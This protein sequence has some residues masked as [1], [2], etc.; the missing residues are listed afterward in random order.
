MARVAGS[1]I[2]MA[3]SR[4]ERSRSASFL[5]SMGSVLQRALLMS[6]TWPGS[7]TWTAKPRADELVVKPGPVQG[8]LD[9]DGDRPIEFAKDGEEAIGGESSM[10]NDNVANRIEDAQSEIAFVEV[11]T[12]EVRHGGLRGLWV[13]RILFVLPE[14]GRTLPTCAPPLGGFPF[15]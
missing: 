8:G 5:A 1:G 9:G 14:T 6:L 13:A 7:A 3:G 4:L 2:Q 11:D 15:S 12:G 10:L